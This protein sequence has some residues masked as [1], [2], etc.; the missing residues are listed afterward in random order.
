MEELLSLK[1]HLLGLKKT[2]FYPI[3]ASLVIAF[4]LLVFAV[5]LLQMLLS[6]FNIPVYTLNP[7]ESVESIF[8]LAV[9]GFIITLIPLLVFSLLK[10]V[11][12]EWNIKSIIYY[13]AG[14]LVLAILGFI[15]GGLFVTKYILNILYTTSIGIP[16]WSMNSVLGASLLFGT[17][18]AVSFQ[19]IILLPLLSKYGLYNK[20][21]LAKGRLFIYPLLL[22]LLNIITPTTDSTSALVCLAPM[23]I[24]LELGN[25]ISKKQTGVDLN[26]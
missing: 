20:E 6:Y 18:F 2:L 7:F 12:T 26:E 14:S 15:S 21:W 13:L 25:M 9:F 24:S 4:G 17:M 22:A 11:N 10:Y 16:Q 3:I 5:P 1:E 23:F 19:L 8:K